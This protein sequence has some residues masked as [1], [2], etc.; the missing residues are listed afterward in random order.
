VVVEAFLI[1]RWARLSF[2][3]KLRAR[4]LIENL[5]LSFALG[6]RPM[7]PVFLLLLNHHNMIGVLFNAILSYF[8][9]PMKLSHGLLH[10]IHMKVYNE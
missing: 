7:F 4:G 10:A 8:N 9:H 1:K 2:C 5:L 3:L 6:R